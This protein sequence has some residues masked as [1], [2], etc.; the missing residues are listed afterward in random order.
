MSASVRLCTLRLISVKP[1]IAYTSPNIETIEG[2]DVKLT[3]IVLLGN[4]TPKITW[5]KMGEQVKT[6]DRIT[7]DASGNLLLRKV[8]VEDEGEYTCVASNPGGNATHATKLDIQ[9]KSAL[10][11]KSTSY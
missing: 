5:F 2:R 4:P 6:G 3:C 7:D 8:K 10:R 9:G 1:V 11:I